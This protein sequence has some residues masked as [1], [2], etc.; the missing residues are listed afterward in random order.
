MA[1]PCSGGNAELADNLGTKDMYD[2]CSQ[3]VRL[4]YTSEASRVISS[5]RGK[6]ELGSAF[7]FG[8]VARFFC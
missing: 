2:V 7:S 5:V 4:S 1:D 3:A 6:R 8:I